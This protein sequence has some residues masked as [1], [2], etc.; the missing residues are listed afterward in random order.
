MRR[1]STRTR[2]NE[3][4][5]VAKADDETW[6]AMEYVG[7]MFGLELRNCHCMSTLSR[8]TERYVDEEC[9]A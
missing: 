3:S 7:E 4:H 2:T 5:E 1:R 9:A 8:P 6:A